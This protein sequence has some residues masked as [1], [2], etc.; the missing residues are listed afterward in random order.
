MKTFAT[1]EDLAAELGL[2]RSTVS[3]ILN[4]Q[5]KSRH[6]SE[7][8]ARKVL[9]F[10]EEVNFTPSLF[11]RALKGKI[12]TD[13][14]ILIP[15]RMYEHHRDTFFT[16][17]DQFAKQDLSYLVLPL[18]SQDNNIFTVRQLQS[19]RC[20]KVII[21]AATLTVKE[22]NW[23]QKNMRRIPEINC[24]FYDYRFEY[25]LNQEFFPSNVHAVGFDRVRSFNMLIE[26]TADKGYRKLCY[27]A[28]FY[29]NEQTF[30]NARERNIEL[31]GI[32]TGNDLEKFADH[33]QEIREPQQ[34]LAVC[35]PDDLASIR[36]IKLLKQRQWNIPDYTGIISWDGLSVSR[37]FTPVLE[38]LEI[39][40]DE[41]CRAAG[42]F[43][44]GNGSGFI[45]VLPVIRSGET[46]PSLF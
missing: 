41:M 28:P 16:F 19:F 44:N 8:T 9:D 30:E 46:L 14:A 35:I 45:E 15:P 32:E 36:L 20:S 24:F 38:T 43:M 17:L 26:H 5:W 40:H 22:L 31:I 34:P 21:F 6:I 2:S 4:G 13:V 27:R 23:W 18:K 42:E 10:T 12:C 7:K 29:T 11:G 25:G 33:I 1:M 3:Y 37:Y 39:P